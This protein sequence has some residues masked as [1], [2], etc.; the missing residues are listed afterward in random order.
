MT[1]AEKFKN[2]SPQKME[3]RSHFISNPMWKSAHNNYLND[4]LNPLYEI[5]DMPYPGID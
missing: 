3:S 5:T 2:Q 4:L 1:L